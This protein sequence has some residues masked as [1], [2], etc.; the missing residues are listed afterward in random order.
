[1]INFIKGIL[2]SLT[3]ESI[4]VE[5]NGIGYEIFLST[6]EIEK[7]SSKINKEIMVYTY[8]IHKEDNMSLFGFLNK[9]TKNF[10]IE[11]L[12]VDGI[13]PKLA[14]K[15]LSNKEPEEIYTYIQEENTEMLKK[16]PGIGQKMV[17]KIILELKDKINITTTKNANNFEKEL[18]SALTNL[19]YDQAIVIEAIKKN[20]IET[21]DFEKEFKRLLKIVSGK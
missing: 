12:K 14:L 15:I 17:G 20:K 10:F 21:D 8:F 6:K 19:G 7:L 3:P 4:I 11:L 1:M 18:I 2:V 9:E 16:I 13:G 5:N